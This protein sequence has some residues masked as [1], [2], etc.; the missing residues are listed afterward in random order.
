MT[1]V[2]GMG[3]TSTAICGA[4]VGANEDLLLATASA[5]AIMG[6]AGEMAAEKAE[7]PGTLQLH[8]LD[9]LYLVDNATI[10]ANLKINH[11]TV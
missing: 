1:K 10:N 11:E 9:A 6:L 8:F 4:F 5:M 2:T 3:C 7:G